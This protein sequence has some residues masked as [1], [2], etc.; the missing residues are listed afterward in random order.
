M[1]DLI[2]KIV[3]CETGEEIE[4]KFTKAEADQY[5]LDIAEHEKYMSDLEKAQELK[6]SAYKKLGLTDEEITAIL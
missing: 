2:K 4:R 1:A 3:N 6:I 5:K